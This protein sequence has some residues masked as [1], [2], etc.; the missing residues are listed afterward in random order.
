MLDPR[1]ESFFTL[2]AAVAFAERQSPGTVVID[3]EG[4]VVFR[5][6]DPAHRARLEFALAVLALDPLDLPPKGL[7]DEVAAAF[8]EIC[9]H[10]ADLRK[11]LSLRGLTPV[12]A[13]LSVKAL[14]TTARLEWL[15]NFLTPTVKES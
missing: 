11:N 13:K 4:K 3:A 14:V 8:G 9:L 12:A 2:I 15:D 6:P 10:F 7:P 5:K 1:R